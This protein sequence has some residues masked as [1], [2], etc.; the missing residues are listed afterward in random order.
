MRGCPKAMEASAWTCSA[1]PSSTQTWPK[2]I[3]ADIVAATPAPD[4]N[5]LGPRLTRQWYSVKVHA[6]QVHARPGEIRHFLNG[7]LDPGRTRKLADRNGGCPVSRPRFQSPQC[8][9]VA[10]NPSPFASI[11][12]RTGITV[13]DNVGQKW[14]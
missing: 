3:T 8:E 11:V 6:E 9:P 5:D 13:S 14:R 12:S 7:Q 10:D 2:A 1:K 4:F